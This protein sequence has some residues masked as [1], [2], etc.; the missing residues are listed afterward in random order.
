ME[1]Y[2]SAAVQPNEDV[3]KSLDFTPKMRYPMRGHSD[4]QIKETKGLK[5]EVRR[6]TKKGM[7]KI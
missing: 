5:S 7:L 3:N 6:G 4:L 2:T 1:M